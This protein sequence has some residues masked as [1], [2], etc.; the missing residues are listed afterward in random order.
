LYSDA[1]LFG[2]AAAWRSSQF[3][4]SRFAAAIQA[5]VY[6]GREGQEGPVYDIIGEGVE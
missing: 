1:Y 5:V 4:D 2:G 3:A 6:Q